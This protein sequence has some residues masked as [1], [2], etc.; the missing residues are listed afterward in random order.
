VL[1]ALQYT[2][3]DKVDG[4]DTPI[5][6]AD[7]AERNRRDDPSWIA[8]DHVKQRKYRRRS[9]TGGGAE[10]VI[11]Q[12]RGKPRHDQ[13]GYALTG[14]ER[15]SATLQGSSSRNSK[16]RTILFFFYRVNKF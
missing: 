3:I 13:E 9:D 16:C 7:D 1:V 11:R 4:A 12:P 15:V 5:N 10:I 6:R 14:D 8:K 2:S